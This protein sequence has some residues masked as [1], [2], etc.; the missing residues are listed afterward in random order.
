M[1]NSTMKPPA[2]INRNL[3]VKLL[4]TLLLP[5]LLVTQAS[6]A[7]AANGYS[8]GK[9]QFIRTHDAGF[10]PS[11]APPFFWFT[12]VGV[13]NAGSCAVFTNSGTVLF[14]ARDKQMYDLIVAAY[15]NGREISV[16]WDDVAVQN[17]DCSARYVTI[18][19]PGN[20]L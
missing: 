4:A 6:S 18:A 15:V 17:G 3:L 2:V 19:N 5:A 1:S 13:T 12:L 9:V 16:Y 8:K 11:F 14:A 10:Y 20:P 7:L